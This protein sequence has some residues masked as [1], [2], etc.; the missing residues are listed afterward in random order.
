MDHSWLSLLHQAFS[1][2]CAG[3]CRAMRSRQSG[4]EN[5]GELWMGHETFSEGEMRDLDATDFAHAFLW[6]TTLAAAIILFWGSDRLWMLV[7]ILLASRWTSI[8]LVARRR[9]GGD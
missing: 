7:V 4:R 9:H 3:F 5:Q 6:L 2:S 8:R 1:S